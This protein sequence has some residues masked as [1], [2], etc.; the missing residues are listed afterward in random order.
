M[1]NQKLNHPYFE[2]NPHGKRYR[3][4]KGIYK[5]CSWMLWIPLI[6][7]LLFGIFSRFGK[8]KHYN[9]ISENWFFYQFFSVLFTIYLIYL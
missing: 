6:G 5:Y 1:K 8:I 3:L 7:I 9:F 4:S 2:K